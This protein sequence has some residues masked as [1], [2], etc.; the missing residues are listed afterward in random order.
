MKILIYAT[1]ACLAAAA[2]S[3]QTLPAPA[4]VPVTATSEGVLRTPLTFQAPAWRL[5][6]TGATDTLSPSESGLGWV[7]ERVTLQTPVGALQFY[8]TGS[9]AEAVVYWPGRLVVTRL[10]SAAQ[11]VGEV[12]AASIT[13]GENDNEYINSVLLQYSLMAP[14][15]HLGDGPLWAGENGITYADGGPG[16]GQQPAAGTYW[17]QGYVAEGD[18]VTRRHIQG[19]YRT[20]AQA[21]ADLA[22]EIADVDGL[23]DSLAAKAPALTALNAQTGTTYTLAL[24]DAGKLV[25]CTNSSAITVTIPAA[26]D[27]EFAIGTTIEIAQGGTGQVTLDPDSGVTLQ[28][29]GGALKTA[30][31]HATAVLTLVDEDTWLVR[32]LLLP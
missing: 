13:R 31:Q 14:L 9:P 18:G 7:D 11:F 8:E 24:S 17:M 22:I 20:S 4:Y 15:T 30:G 21:K 19:R 28:S 6:G 27:V 10:E 1:A 26:G 16:I 25:I 3:A 5:S 12:G 23:A 2:L 32:G 29:W